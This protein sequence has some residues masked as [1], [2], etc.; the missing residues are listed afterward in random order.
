ML[1]TR[2][3]VLSGWLCVL[4][5]SYLSVLTDRRFVKLSTRRLTKAQLDGACGDSRFDQDF[6]VDLIFADVETDSSSQTQ[7]GT[8][9]RDTAAVLGDQLASLSLTL[10]VWYMVWMY[11]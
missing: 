8:S 6:F 7:P 4:A 1:L 2:Q 11:D 5:T 9:S 3:L 10:S